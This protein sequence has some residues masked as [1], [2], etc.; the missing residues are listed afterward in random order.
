MGNKSEDGYQYKQMV[1]GLFYF[2]LIALKHVH[3]CLFYKALITSTIVVK[4]SFIQQVQ[5]WGFTQA[6]A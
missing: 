1:F 2:S 5:S 6:S 4:L 3:D